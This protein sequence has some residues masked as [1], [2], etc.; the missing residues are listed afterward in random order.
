MSALETPAAKAAPSTAG[1]SA[2]LSKLEE[3]VK[4]IG[5]AGDDRD[6]AI[7]TIGKALEA[8]AEK[9][10]AIDGFLC[11]EYNQEQDEGNEIRSLWEVDWLGA[12]G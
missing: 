4:V 1:V 12:V 5:V 10:D 3:M 6:K 8:L 9:I 2:D 7:K 11:Y